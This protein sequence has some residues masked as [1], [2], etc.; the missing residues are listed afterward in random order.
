[1]DSRYDVWIAPY[2]F[3]HSE[4][5][6]SQDI[7]SSPWLIAAYHVLRRLP[8]PRHSPCALLSLTMRCKTFFWNVCAN[9]LLFFRFD[10]YCSLLPFFLWVLQLLS[11]S[12]LFFVVQ[13]SR[14]VNGF[15][16]LKRRSGGHKTPSHSPLIG[17][18]GFAVKL[19][20]GLLL[21]FRLLPP[22]VGTSGFEPPTS[23]LSGVRSNH[24]S[25]APIPVVEMRRIELLT[26]CVQGRCSPS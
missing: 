2:G 15:L 24:L 6:G 13:F 3:L 18:Y 25:Y 17:L 23:R 22:L 16:P 4:I 21:F 9:L 10:K 1:M 12:Q 14:C 26:P 5:H 7:C 19:P 8:V 11:H 20:F